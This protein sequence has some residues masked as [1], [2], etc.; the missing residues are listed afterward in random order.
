M[1]LIQH[2]PQA[3][4]PLNTPPGEIIAPNLVE[5]GTPI[6]CT[7]EITQK[8]NMVAEGVNGSPR[9]PPKFDSTLIKGLLMRTSTSLVVNSP[10]TVSLGYGATYSLTTQLVRGPTPQHDSN[11]PSS[12]EDDEARAMPFVRE[13]TL[14]ALASFSEVSLRGKRAVFHAQESS[15]FARHLTSYL[16]SWGVDIGHMPIG[17]SLTDNAVRSSSGTAKLSGGSDGGVDDTPVTASPTD[18]DSA[19]LPPQSSVPLLS[20]DASGM[21][22]VEPAAQIEPSFVIIDDD[23]DV[24]R[25][26]L[27]RYRPEISP[28]KRPSLAQNHRPRSSPQIRQVLG[29]SAN[30]KKL[31][32]SRSGQEERGGIIV[33]ITS[34]AKYKLV[35]DAVQSAISLVPQSRIPD[36]MVIPKPVGPRRFLTALYTAVR[37]PLVDPYFFPIATSPQSPGTAMGNISAHPARTLS[38]DQRSG[39]AAPPT[40]ARSLQQ[41]SSPYGGASGHKPPREQTSTPTIRSSDYGTPQTSPMSAADSLGYFAPAAVKMGSSASSGVVLQS[42]DGRPTG[43]YFQPQRGSTARKNESRIGT[44]ISRS[45]RS[46]VADNSPNSRYPPGASSSRFAEEN[47]PAPLLRERRTSSE[48]NTSCAS[49]SR[50]K[51]YASADDNPSTPLIPS[52]PRPTRSRPGSS[53][54]RPTSA[55]SSRDANSSSSAPQAARVIASSRKSSVSRQV[56]GG[57]VVTSP[58][59]AS[60]AASTLPVSSLIAPKL[61]PIDATTGVVGH[62]PPLANG[63]PKAT[64]TVEIAVSVVLP[65]DV[66]PGSAASIAS[67]VPSK[68][69]T[70]Q[71]RVSGSGAAKGMKASNGITPPISV[72][73]AEGMH[74]HRRPRPVSHT[75]S[76]Q[77]D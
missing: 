21:T 42:P 63:P 68:I 33:H 75:C 30:E 25:R 52:L 22:P 49:L 73:I 26:T 36:I 14:E 20:S 11:P 29:M 38:S 8:A 19:I 62:S 77:S 2:P 28:T 44:P 31:S 32:H 66:S 67:H 48:T 71:K 5:V 53:R 41:A 54:S 7:F 72:L 39:G 34:L 55:G 64:P 13:P 15:T 61:T 59:S 17:G 6:S 23:V 51:R 43:I 10:S 69:R 12:L 76:R 4:D 24:L 40:T 37:K 1:S 47:H 35:K 3:E 60:P 45:L 56:P 9:V 57:N 74:L 27:D 70:K 18:V 46:P 58:A 50:S 65:T 16:T